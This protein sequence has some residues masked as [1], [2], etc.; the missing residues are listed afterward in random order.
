[1]RGLDGRSVAS[2]I[3]GCSRGGVLFVRVKRPCVV[4]GGVQC[5]GLCGFLQVA[6]L[7]RD[8][9]P[10]HNPHAVPTQVQRDCTACMGLRRAVL[11]ACPVP[12]VPSARLQYA[13]CT[14]CFLRAVQRCVYCV[15]CLA[16]T[17][18]MLRAVLWCA[19]CWLFLTWRGAFCREQG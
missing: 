19:F 6:E 3:L 8:A 12:C 5:E 15:L 2:S 17:L 14:K 11:P 7:L 9:M 13:C 10:P 1:M 16:C 18:S 4:C